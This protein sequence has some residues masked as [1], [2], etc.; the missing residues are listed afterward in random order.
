MDDA[1]RI[2]VMDPA[3][4]LRQAEHSITKK[5]RASL[6]TPFIA[7]IRRYELIRPGDRIAVCISGGKDSMLLAKMMQMLERYTEI[8]FET[9]Y[10]VMD[11]A[12]ARPTGGRS[13]RTPG[14]SG[15]P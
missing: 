10:L 9:Q 13:R 3:E 12:T 6:W 4:R 8:P 5:Y 11:P 1:E 7:A 15:S 14:S 2:P